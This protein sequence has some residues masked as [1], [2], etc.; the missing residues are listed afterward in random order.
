MF[1]ITGLFLDRFND[2]KP[3]FGGIFEFLM[4]LAEIQIYSDALYVK[5]H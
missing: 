4:T 3:F 2:E 5:L 1:R